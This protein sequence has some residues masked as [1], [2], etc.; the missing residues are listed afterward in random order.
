LLILLVHGGRR[1]DALIQY[2]KCRR[3]LDDELGIEPEAETVQL[4]ERVLVG[5]LHAERPV[6]AAS[7]PPGPAVDT[8][9]RRRPGPHTSFIG[10]E[11]ELAQITGQSHVSHGGP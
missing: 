6:L 3:L 4:Y 11:V 7:A 2:E 8:G 5:E 1:N 9:W 10:R